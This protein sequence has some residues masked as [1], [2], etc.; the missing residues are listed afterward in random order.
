MKQYED[1]EKGCDEQIA[2]LK[3]M[4]S[5]TEGQKTVITSKKNEWIQKQQ[6]FEKNYKDQKDKMDE[7][8]QSNQE[9]LS[10]ISTDFLNQTKDYLVNLQ[11]FEKK[12]S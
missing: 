1:L 4:I 3:K 12:Y 2:C 10:Q 7:F 5:K 11:D 9:T 6:E 8:M